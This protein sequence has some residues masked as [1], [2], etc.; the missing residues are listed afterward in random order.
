M[1]KN[2]FIPINFVVALGCVGIVSRTGCPTHMHTRTHA[3]TH[4]NARTH[5]ITHACM[6]TH[7]HA[8][9]HTHKPIHTH[10]HTHSHTRMHAYTYTHTH[11]HTH[12]HHGGVTVWTAGTGAAKLLPQHG[13]P[14]RPTAGQQRGVHR[15]GPAHRPLPSLL[16]LLLSQH[17]LQG[18]KVSTGVRME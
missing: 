13:G 11:T 5:A 16:L 8:H 7:I 9:T 15:G 1:F 3:R 2:F 17:T 18:T 14:E 6:H 10:T 4:S 12:Y